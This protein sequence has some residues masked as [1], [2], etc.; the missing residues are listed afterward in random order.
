M[1][2]ALSA[3]C[4]FVLFL[5]CSKPGEDPQVCIFPRVTEMLRPQTQCADAWGYGKNNDETIKKFSN[6]LLQKNIVAAQIIFQK[7]GDEAVCLACT[8]SKGYTIHVWVEDQYISS[9][10]NEGFKKI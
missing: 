10:A 7:T 1:K 9:L 4:L 2:T 6:Y 3:A 8:C 5:A